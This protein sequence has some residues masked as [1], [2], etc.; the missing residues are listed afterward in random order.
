[1]D[2]SLY[3]DIAFHQSE[4]QNY[5]WSSQP[6]IEALPWD[7]SISSEHLPSTPPLLY[8]NDSQACSIQAE[9]ELN[10]N[11]SPPIPS[12]PRP[13]NQT[14]SH[15]T[16][17]PCQVLHEHPVSDLRHQSP[18]RFEEDVWKHGLDI[19]PVTI[20]AEWLWGVKDNV[21]RERNNHKSQEH[22]QWGSDE[23]FSPIWG[24][25]PTCN[26]KNEFEL[27][28]GIIHFGV[29]EI[30]PPKHHLSD[31]SE[32]PKVSR[33][34]A[35][36]KRQSH[37]DTTRT[38]REPSILER[39]PSSA[40]QHNSHRRLSQRLKDESRATL[41]SILL[42][43]VRHASP[44]LDWQIRD[45]LSAEATRQNHI[46]SEQRRRASVREGF[47]ELRSIVPSLQYGS[48]SRSIMLVEA[49]RWLESLLAE[50]ETLELYAEEL[51]QGTRSFHF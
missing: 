34:A 10:Y 28:P 46:V 39:K 4:P 32:R 2:I 24:F 12:T 8:S 21:S 26:A 43:Q 17:L 35:H 25:S 45:K 9:D 23:S 20:F 44:M 13:H 36:I 27:A 11:N 50:M 31:L 40:P 3:S 18:D 6:Y 37:K 30:S 38:R 16:T 48:P 14:I 22:L 33:T 41:K 1:M 51:E 15:N 47:Y 5:A 49:A 42:Q 29:V 7:L 19:V